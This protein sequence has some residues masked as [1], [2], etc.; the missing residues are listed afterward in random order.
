[1]LTSLLNAGEYIVPVP[2]EQPNEEWHI[3]LSGLGSEAKK[4]YEK[5]LEDIIASIN[6]LH[7]CYFR[8]HPYTPALR[9]EIHQGVSSNKYQLASL[10]NA[11]D[12]QCGT[13]GIMEPY[14]LFM[15]DRMVKNLSKAIPAFRQTV[16]AERERPGH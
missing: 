8:P 12:F 1:M 10:F 14:P 3:G 4:E 11:I 5:L 6:N 7:V 13:P 9:I 2:Y 15:A 16:Q